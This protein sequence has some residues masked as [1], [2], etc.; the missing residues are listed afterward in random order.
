M[1]VCGD[2]AWRVGYARPPEGR[3]RRRRTTRR[4][5]Y[6][7]YGTQVSSLFPATTASFYPI[8]SFS[9]LNVCQRF[10]DCRCH[11]LLL[12][13]LLSRPGDYSTG[14]LSIAHA[15][16]NASF[17]NSPPTYV[18]IRNW[19]EQSLSLL[20]LISNIHDDNNKR[21]RLLSHIEEERS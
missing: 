19:Y 5:Q 16:V 15:S 6:C 20:E 7:V 2:C 14:K 10:C 8:A 18:F 11:I 12:R 17:F 13:K 21:S 4:I 3:R 9:L 1:W